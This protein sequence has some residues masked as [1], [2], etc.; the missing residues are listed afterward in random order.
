MLDDSIAGT[1]MSVGKSVVSLSIWL[2][3]ILHKSM[4]RHLTMASTNADKLFAVAVDTGVPFHVMSTKTCEVFQQ[5]MSV[6][7]LCALG[8]VVCHEDPGT[9]VHWFWIHLIIC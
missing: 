4:Q 2:L 9:S 8:K 1:G 3:T 7:C 5:L 6:N